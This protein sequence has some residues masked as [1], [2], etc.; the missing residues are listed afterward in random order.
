MP[1]DSACTCRTAASNPL[2]AARRAG[3]AGDRAR[4]SSPTS[5]RP[6]RRTSRR[7]ETSRDV[8][9]PGVLHSDSF[10][11]YA[12]AFFKISRSSSARRSCLRSRLFSSRSSS[13]VAFSPHGVGRRGELG[14]PGSQALLAHAHGRRGRLERVASP[15]TTS[16]TASCLNSSLNRR[17]RRGTSVL[18]SLILRTSFRDHYPVPAAVRKSWAIANPPIDEGYLVTTVLSTGPATAPYTCIVECLS[19]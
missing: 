7:W 2:A 4:R 8:P 10:A 5:K 1:C 9:D 15:P 6:A 17:R 16:R 12:V 13:S 14:V 18:N 3:S 11:K 19:R